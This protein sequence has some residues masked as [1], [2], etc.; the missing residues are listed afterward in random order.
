MI[1]S[2]EAPVV[3][4]HD[5]VVVRIVASKPSMCFGLKLAFMG[6]EAMGVMLFKDLKSAKFEFTL[7]YWAILSWL[8]FQSREKWWCTVIIKAEILFYLV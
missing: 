2:P 3:G 1:M 4:Y 8:D 6:N 5:G 7:T